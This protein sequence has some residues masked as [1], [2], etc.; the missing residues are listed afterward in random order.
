M[1]LM[2]IFESS[3]NKLNLHPFDFSVA[4]NFDYLADFWTKKDA[5]KGAVKDP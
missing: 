3:N 2:S 1:K 5:P 4:L